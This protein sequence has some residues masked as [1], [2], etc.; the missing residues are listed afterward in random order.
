VT[1]RNSTLGLLALALAI[2]VGVS[3]PAQHAASAATERYQRAETEHR[4][5]S[6][7]LDRLQKTVTLLTQLGAKGDA[8]GLTPFERAARVRRDI[9]KALRT[10]HVIHVR[11]EV[12]PG[13]APTIATVSLSAEAAFP[14]LMQLEAQ[15][16][17][18]GSG[19]VLERLSIGQGGGSMSL[20]ASAMGE[21]S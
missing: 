4:E 11:L 17:R 2:Y 15:L 6:S 21:T 9:V 7:R 8:T 16:L 19:L 5:A 18:P 14:A 12:R 10:A 3:T 1:E 13:T 20:E